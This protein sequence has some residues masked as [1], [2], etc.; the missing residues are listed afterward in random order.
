[1]DRINNNIKFYTFIDILETYSDKNVSLS[2]KEINHHIKKRLGIE[3]DRRTIYNYMRDMKAL[4]F[5]VSDYDKDKEG[6]YLN[7]HR[8]EPHE[9]KIL[10]DAV[11]TS[12]FI[13]HGK[14]L[15]LLEKL[16][17]FNS[18]YQNSNFIQNIFIEDVPKS[19]NEEI[20]GSMIVLDRAIK[21][22]K[23]VMFNYCNYDCFKNLVCRVDDD[24]EKKVY[25]KSPVYLVLRNKN[26][27]LVC[28]DEECEVLQNYRVDRMLNVT[29]MDEDIMD[30][31]KFVDCRNGFNPMEYLRKSFKMFSGENAIVVVA[32]GDNLLNYFLDEFGEYIYIMKK[33]DFRKNNL[34]EEVRLECFGYQILEKILGKRDYNERIL[35]G[36]YMEEAS[37]RGKLEDFSRELKRIV[38]ICEDECDEEKEARD[39][40]ESGSASGGGKKYIGIFVAKSGV[41]LAKWIL[42]FGTDVE[43]VFPK[44]LRA[45]VKSEIDGMNEYYSE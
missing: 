14:S 19:A 29:V 25:V 2:V 11:L 9:I 13:T 30:L 26:Y 22:C 1:M 8:L 23:K 28:A 7:S 18:I 39:Q 20:F 10:S 45:L 40:E 16:K 12:N 44:S 24:G 37:T 34:E 6:Y 15:A 43:V 33:D 41:G 21:D 42:Q 3:L 35:T 31:S 5:D 36:R 27:Y 32:F 38:G 4:G 17:T